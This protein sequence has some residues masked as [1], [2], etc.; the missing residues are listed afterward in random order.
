VPKHPSDD[1]AFEHW[2]EWVFD[3]PV[4][5]PEWYQGENANLWTASPVVTVDYITRLFEA[6]PACL[7]K[8]SD[9]Q[10]SQGLWFLASS[11]VFDGLSNVYSEGVLRSQRHRCVSSIYTLFEEYFAGRC[12]PHLSHINEAG[13]NPLNVTCYMWWDFLA[14]HT[15]SP[16][17]RVQSEMDSEIL[18]VMANT[19][20]LNHD[21]CTESALHG[22]GHWHD[23]CS[24][25]V[26]AIIDD[27]LA[28][29]PKLRPE[30]HDYALEARAGSI[31]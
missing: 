3:H 9:A 21:A 5:D 23:Y 4:T 24:A 26:V 25:E 11:I 16:D 20:R 27:F 30:L 14:H 2:V 10:A 17:G 18:S 6:A 13:A 7:Q 15:D 8:F 22:L 29:H 31:L 1:L 12:S 28:S 19:L